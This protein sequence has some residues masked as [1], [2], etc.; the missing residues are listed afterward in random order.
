M[1]IRI[2]LVLAVFVVFY[3]SGQSSSL[4]D[5]GEESG[6]LKSAIP[7]GPE[8]LKSTTAVGT[9]QQLAFGIGDVGLYAMDPSGSKPTRLTG[10]Y[11]PAWSPDGEQIAYTRDL[12]EPNPSASSASASADSE[13]SYT[14]T[15]SIF[16]MNADGSGGKQLVD[17]A[18]VGT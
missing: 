16:V 3:L 1:A 14:E 12:K 17:K 7:V 18:V 10:G 6:E 15:P 2:L 5:Q 4:A 13:S 8:Q 11:S 9:G